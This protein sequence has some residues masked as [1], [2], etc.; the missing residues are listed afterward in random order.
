MKLLRDPALQAV[1]GILS[2][3]IAIL[4]LFFV[5]QETAAPQTF[6]PPATT[7]PRAGV[8]LPFDATYVGTWRDMIGSRFSCIMSLEI[9]ADSSVTGQILWTLEASPFTDLQSKIGLNA[10]EYVR[11]RYEP[12][13]ST[14]EIDGYE[15]DDPYRIIG[16]GNYTLTL[17]ADG[18]RITGI[19]YVLGEIDGTFDAIRQS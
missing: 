19:N 1:A 4:A 3:V 9:E 6:T 7:A 17:P 13:T 15:R 8:P 12:T 5:R 11:G 2:L 18:S 14:L 10:A 16:L